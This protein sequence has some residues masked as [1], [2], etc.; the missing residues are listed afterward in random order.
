[1]RR[2]RHV[3]TVHVTDPPKAAVRRRSPRAKPDEVVEPKEVRGSIE[4]IPASAI[5]G[6]LGGH[7]VHPDVSKARVLADIKARVE[8][9]GA[10]G[11]VTKTSEVPTVK[12]RRPKK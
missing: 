12:I 9:G 3:E 4:P 10:P 11:V 7:P 8:I 6:K 5:L 1:M 2:R